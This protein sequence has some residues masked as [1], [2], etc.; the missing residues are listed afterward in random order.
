MDTLFRLVLGP[1]CL[2]IALI[3]I[4]AWWPDRNMYGFGPLLIAGLWL[5]ASGIHRLVR[6]RA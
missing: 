1:L 5:I 4:T 2:F 6:K 3:Q